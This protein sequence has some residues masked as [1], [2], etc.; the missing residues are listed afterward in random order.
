M[1][2]SESNWIEWES[3]ID[4]NWHLLFEYSTFQGA[5]RNQQIQC[6]SWNTVCFDCW[7]ES[8]LISFKEK[9][10]NS[11]INW[12]GL[13]FVRA[14]SIISIWKIR[15]IFTMNKQTNVTQISFW[16]EKWKI[17]VAFLLVW[18]T[19]KCILHFFMPCFLRSQFIYF[20]LFFLISK[21]L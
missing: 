13:F 3:Q 21:Y 9:Y 20:F 19:Q 7:T 11:L 1:V 18:L 12:N 15:Q 10:V 8:M 4:V 6:R 16:C 17:F 2:L 5:T 14:N